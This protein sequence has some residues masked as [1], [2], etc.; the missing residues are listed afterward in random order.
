MLA[1]PARPG[2]DRRDGLEAS[3]ESELRGQL[4]WNSLLVD[5]AGRPV[6]APQVQPA[7]DGNNPS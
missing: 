2:P 5:A 6:Q 1:L 3:Y 4:G 7:R